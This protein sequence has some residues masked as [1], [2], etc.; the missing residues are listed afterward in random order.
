MV[1]TK[2]SGNLM[3]LGAIDFGL[4]VDGAVVLAENIVRMLAHRQH[5][6]GRLLNREE[7][8][9]TILTACKQVGRPMVFGVA[10]ITIVYFPILSLTGVEGK[11]FKPMAE[12]VIFALIGALILALTVVPA[13]CSF[14]MTRKVRE[15]DN[16]II[17][18]AKR[19]Y[20]P[21]FN[22]AMK[23]RWLVT[24]GAVALFIVAAL[25]FTRLGAVFVPKLDDGE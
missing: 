13:L 25:L 22:F 21:L 11:T 16:F 24:G 17:H 23:F 2:V 5:Q 1:Q 20:M 19:L 9:H 3:S 4:I 18:W 6:L 15:E 14:L 7:R 8:L 12:T 10:I